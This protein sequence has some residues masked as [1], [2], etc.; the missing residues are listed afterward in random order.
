ME[1]VKFLLMVHNAWPEFNIANV[2]QSSL[3][4]GIA[5]KRKGE[6]PAERTPLWYAAYEGHTEIVGLLINS[7]DADVNC[8][9]QC[10]V[11]PL[12]AAVQRGHEDVVKVL[13]KVPHI[14][15]NH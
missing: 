3:E 2:S 14:D 8:Q 4:D 1:V 11:T 12:I 13:L 15:I 6:R 7:Y 5:F 10:G 9:D